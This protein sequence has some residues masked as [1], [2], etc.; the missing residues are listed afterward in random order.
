MITAYPPK[1]GGAGYH[2]TLPSIKYEKAISNRKVDMES[3]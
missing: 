2:K 3:K 1:V